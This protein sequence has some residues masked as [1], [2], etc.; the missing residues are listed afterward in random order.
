MSQKNA[1]GANPTQTAL[2]AESALRTIS[3][4]QAAVAEL[5]ARID[6][7]LRAGLPVI[8]GLFSP[9]SFSRHG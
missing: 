6:G 5:A 3:L 2:F 4:E 9:H 7:A 8:N 1:E